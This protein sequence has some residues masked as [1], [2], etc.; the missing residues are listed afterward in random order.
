MTGDGYTC[1]YRFM[2]HL[3]AT[4]CALPIILCAFRLLH[5]IILC[6]N[7]SRKPVVHILSCLHALSVSLFHALDV[8][9]LY[10]SSLVYVSKYPLHATVCLFK[11]THYYLMHEM[12]CTV[13]HVIC[14]PFLH[15]TEAKQIVEEKIYSPQSKCCVQEEISTQ[16]E[17]PKKYHLHAQLSPNNPRLGGVSCLCPPL[18]VRAALE[19]SHLEIETHSSFHIHLHVQLPHAYAIFNLHPS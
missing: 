11:V 17:A 6:I 16:S 19:L 3:V 9:F 13:V 10:R 5:I 7:G 1:T 18:A 12:I 15:P 2:C 14:F 8:S 4:C